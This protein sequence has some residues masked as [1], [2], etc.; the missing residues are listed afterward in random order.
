MKTNDTRIAAGKDAKPELSTFQ[1]GNDTKRSGMILFLLLM[2]LG[3]LALLAASLLRVVL[4]EVKGAHYSYREHRAF[5]NAEAGVQFICQSISQDLQAGTL[6]MSSPVEAVNYT[7]PA[8]YDFDPVTELLALPDNDAYAF[9]VTGRHE[10]AR[11]PIEVSVTRPRL[12]RAIGVFGD[13][14][15]SLQPKV[16][17]YS[18][19][20]SVML[21]PDAADSTG[22]ANAGSN[23]EITIRPGAVIDGTI[24]L[25]EDWSGQP[26]A[27]PSGYPSEEVGPINPDPLGAIGGAL[28]DGFAYY[29]N[30][31]NNDNLA[32]GI[33]GNEIDISPGSTLTLPGGHYYLTDVYMPPN[34]TL[35][36]DATPTNPA[37]IYLNGQMRIQ[38][39]SVINFSAGQPSNFFVFSN[40]S[41]DVL[42]QPNGAFYGFV[43]APY[44]E[45]DLQ[46]NGAIH[47]IYWG[48]ETLIQPG[49]QIF[50][51]IDLLDQFRAGSVIVEQWRRIY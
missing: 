32:A 2:L 51:D 14:K 15:L 22:E 29:Q 19:R 27:V 37:I 49:N 13:D 11:V 44:A 7:A 28:A 20:S 25:G 40:S 39:K 5:Y 33:V 24:I 48:K 34:S 31:A 18:Y 6:Q 35:I 1:P 30:P 26:P 42:I 38:P 16:E 46:P 12:M 17:I 8:G 43:Y 45:L 3:L 23:S 21:N 47:G 41:D 9:V 4:P 10:N 50:I 36:V